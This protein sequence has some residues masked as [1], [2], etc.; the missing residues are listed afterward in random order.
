MPDST[1]RSD[2][3]EATRRSDGWQGWQSLERSHR[4]HGCTAGKG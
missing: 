2:D 4:N 1:G 3:F